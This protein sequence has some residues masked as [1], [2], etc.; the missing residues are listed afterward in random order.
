VSVEPDLTVG[1]LGRLARE[2]SD[3]SP[4]Q[5]LGSYAV[6]AWVVAQTLETVSSLVGLPLWFGRFTII[7]L[8]I[9][10]GV[11]ALTAAVQRGSA[12][13][14]ASDPGEPGTP[15][16]DPARPP[17]KASAR[18]IRRWFSWRNALRAGLVAF[19]LLGALTAAFTL[20]RNMGVGPAAS[21][22]ASGALEENGGI[23]IADFSGEDAEL[24]LSV[25][26]ALRVDLAGLGVESSRSV[27]AALARM[28]L[29]QNTLIDADVARQ[30]AI[31]E[32]LGAILAGEV[33]GLGEGIVITA[34]LETPDGATLL[35]ARESA[36]D[37]SGVIPALDR[38]S[39]HLR[40][41]IG[42]SLRSIQRAPP[43]DRVTTP[44]LSA[45]RKF[46]LGQRAMIFDSE[47]GRAAALLEEAIAEDTAFA[48]A[49]RLLGTLRG[50]QQNR[51]AE[52]EALTQAYRHRDR[53]SELER[54][55]TEATYHDDITSDRQRAIAAYQTVLAI[56]S[57][58]IS[59]LNNVGIIFH[60]LRD[61]E[62]AVEYYR[63]ALVIEPDHVIPTMNLTYPLAAMGDAPAVE[64]MLDRLDALDTGG[65]GY[66]MRGLWLSSQRE[67]EAAEQHLRAT[68]SF[69]SENVYY[70][71]FAPTRLAALA[72]T[73]GRLG[74]AEAELAAIRP[75]G[76]D[77]L[78]AAAQRAGQA[79][80]VAGDTA[81]ALSV[82]DEA[83]LESPLDDI[84]PLDRPYLELASG[85]AAAGRSPRALA[86]WEAYESAF[87]DDIKND[88]REERLRVEGEIALAEGRPEEALR[89]FRDSELGLCV[90]CPWP[91]VAR[92]LDAAGRPR[93][94][95]EAYARYVDGPAM[96]RITVDQ[97]YLAFALERLGQLYEELGD[98]E[99]SRARY[100]EFVDLLENA[101]P[102]LAPRVEAARAKLLTGG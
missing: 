92:A 59:A 91:L 73:R 14:A 30:L 56:D 53:L 42:E 27:G 7:L 11:L 86:L 43:L 85:F 36:S 80:L 75:P 47:I 52:V 78:R 33:S 23:L 63:T 5:V 72:A 2:L 82:I 19:A 95:I 17:T 6:G 35:T 18:G 10:G 64:A 4:W 34:R 94:A 46:T 84:E 24:G 93:E 60:E 70:Q 49:Y 31:R 69:A 54:A 97:Y 13:D 89:L 39:K 57:A 22:L 67:W 65:A 25:S 3:R 38:L 74:E 40:E 98:V 83:L 99:N 1:L 20:S 21:L 55:L 96:E 76:A 101:D 88:V 58:S 29:E 68:G 90:A 44:S 41:R 79:L 26:E 8:L 51:S 15:P 45:L 62:T 28:G 16:G 9:G 37:P 102:V 81:A 50:N 12:P 71:T 48:M 77:F 61:F 87:P 66:E 100:R 32:G